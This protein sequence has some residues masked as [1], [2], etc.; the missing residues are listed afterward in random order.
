MISADD[1][2]S[3]AAILFGLAFLGFWTENTSIGRKTSGVVWVICAGILLGNMGV[4]PLKSPAYDFV[5]G[6]LMPI[7]IP[8]LLL[9][10]DLRRIFTE[11]GKVMFAFS[12]AVIGTLIGALIGYLIFDLGPIG[13]KAT[14]VY[15]AGWIGGAVNFVAVSDALGMTPAEFSIAMGASSPVSVIALMLL[16]AIPSVALIRKHIP[17]KIIDETDGGTEELKLS[18]EEMPVM[19]T[20]GVVALSA[21]ICS[22]ANIIAGWLAMTQYSVL[23]ITII[24]LIIANIIPARLSKVKGDFTLGMMIMYLFFAAIGCS[25]D[26]VSFIGSAMIL[27]FFGL[28]IILIHLFVALACAKVFKVDLAEILIASAAAL[29]GPAPAAAIASAR[30]WPTLVTPGIM[31]GIFGYAIANFIGVGIGNWLGG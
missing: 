16:A 20:V 30:N 24:S 29:V 11:S 28:F 25:T 19:H 31:V 27:F 6:T 18:I 21:A 14:A 2:F 26:A 5:G 8:L 23:F 3:L 4:V 10:A 22:A 12:F 15:T 1:H 9:K 7:A 13:P 17:S